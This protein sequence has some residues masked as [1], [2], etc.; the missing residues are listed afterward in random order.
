[1]SIMN[2]LVTLAFTVIVAHASAGTST[3]RRAA[4]TMV[5]FWRSDKAES[6]CWVVQRLSDGRFARKEYLVAEFNKPVEL[7]LSWGQWKVDGDVYSI[8]LEGTTSKFLKQFVSRSTRFKIVTRSKT[9]FVFVSHDGYDRHETRIGKATSLM[10]IRMDEG[11]E[12]VVDTTKHSVEK[13]PSW[14]VGVQH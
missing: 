4:E 1:M 5:G 6:G 9:R 7:V 12:K 14:I 11:G 2:R 10:N 8:T 13:L 3:P